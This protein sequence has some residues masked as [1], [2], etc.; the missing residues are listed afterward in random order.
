MDESEIKKATALIWG[1]MKLCIEPSAGVGVACV[2]S[3][4][5]RARYPRRA[6]ARRSGSS[7]AA[8]IWIWRSRIRARKFSMDCT[9]ACLGAASARRQAGRV[10]TVWEL[11][12]HVRLAVRVCAIRVPGAPCALLDAKPPRAQ[13]FASNL[14]GLR[15]TSTRSTDGHFLFI[16]R[17]LRGPKQPVK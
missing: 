10:Y 6:V 2:L 16:T 14:A 9:A 13:N 17:R 7:S 15:H 11:N 4:A 5:F 12:Q 1:R 8:G 3:E